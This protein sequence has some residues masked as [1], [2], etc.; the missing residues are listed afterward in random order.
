MVEGEPG[1]RGAEDHGEAE[2]R[3][4]TSH[5]PS[6]RLGRGPVGDD[7]CEA[8]DGESQ[9]ERQEADDRVEE[10]AGRDQCHEEE[11]EGDKDE[12]ADE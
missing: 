8:R 10:D 3:L 5:K 12:F 4:Q 6:L 9:A 7:G 1:C 11:V 2:D